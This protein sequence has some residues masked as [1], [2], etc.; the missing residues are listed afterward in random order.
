MRFPNIAARDLERTD[1]T[2]PDDLPGSWRL[3]L[4]P[5][6]RWQ[7]IVV[8]AWIDALAPLMDAHPELT[9]WEVPTLSS[10]W[11]PARGYVDGGMRAGIPDVD[12]RRHTLTAYTPLNQI[13]KALA[14]P[15]FDEVQVF[16]LDSTGEIVWR[17]AGEP[18]PQ[19]AI[20][21]AD[22][23]VADGEMRA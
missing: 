18:D 22:A 3:V 14:I 1:Y 16:L 10:A 11:T 4:M 5:F 15:G 8:G 13:A 7:Q 21:L 12:V 17:S 20:A 23:L 6:K 19:K 9:V 2:L